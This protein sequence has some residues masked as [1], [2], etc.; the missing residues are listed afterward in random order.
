MFTFKLEYPRVI[1]DMPYYTWQQSSNPLLEKTVAGYTGMITHLDLS[2][3]V[4][5]VWA[6]VP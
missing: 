2:R 3:S 4:L 5:A 1:D 6:I